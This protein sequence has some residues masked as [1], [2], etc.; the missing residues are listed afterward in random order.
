M[1]GNP[2]GQV[3]LRSLRARLNTQLDRY[4]TPRPGLSDIIQFGV[5]GCMLEAQVCILYRLR[6][7]LRFQSLR[8]LRCQRCFICGAVSVSFAVPAVV[9]LVVYFVCFTSGFR[10]G[11]LASDVSVMKQGCMRGR[12]LDSAFEFAPGC[13]VDM[14]INTYSAPAH[15]EHLAA[16]MQCKTQRRLDTEHFVSL[17]TYVCYFAS[18]LLFRCWAFGIAIEGLSIC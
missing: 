3:G 8:N 16:S 5:K 10:C 11:I 17:S 7:Q 4:I 14:S 13:C 2:I 15:S 6:F 12:L 18:V 9:S 1:D